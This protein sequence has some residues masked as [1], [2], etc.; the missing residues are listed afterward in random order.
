MYVADASRHTECLGLFILCVRSGGCCVI[1]WKAGLLRGEY[2][3]RTLTAL[4]AIFVCR[5]ADADVYIWSRTAGPVGLTPLSSFDLD[6][7]LLALPPSRGHEV[8]GWVLIPAFRG[9]ALRHVHEST[10]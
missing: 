6:R 3:I 4:P 9:A 8:R 7:E 5:Q 1:T 10:A 2:F